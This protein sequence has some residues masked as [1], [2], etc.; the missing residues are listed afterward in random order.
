M[1]NARWFA[2]LN[3]GSLK[4]SEGFL[5]AV[6]PTLFKIGNVKL[7]FVVTEQ[8]LNLSFF[9]PYDQQSVLKI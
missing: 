8:Q 1:L 7:E 3:L 5:Y 4:P 2:M 9:I 6:L